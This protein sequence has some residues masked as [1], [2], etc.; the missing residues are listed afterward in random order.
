VGRAR[1]VVTLDLA[2]EAALSAVEVEG[3]A[4]ALARGAGSMS[5]EDRERV[6]GKLAADA[7]RLRLRAAL[8][9]TGA[10]LLPSLAWS[11]EYDLV[12]EK[13]ID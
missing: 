3:M 8:E 11:G 10:V 5:D 4:L 12:G 13:P 7:R 9:G 2:Q 1:E 6:T